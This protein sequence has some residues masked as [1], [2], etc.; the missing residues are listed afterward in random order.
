MIINDIGFDIATDSN[1]FLN[2]TLNVRIEMPQ[3]VLNV[4]KL[5][6][7]F[8]SHRPY[9]HHAYS[10]TKQQTVRRSDKKE[11]NFIY[12]IDSYKSIICRSVSQSQTFWTLNE[13]FN[14][15][16]YHRYIRILS[17]SH[18]HRLLCMHIF[19]FPMNQFKCIWEWVEPSVCLSVCMDVFVWWLIFK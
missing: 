16:K 7:D 15:Y 11:R 9:K 12:L 10:S 5:L 3:S 14:M 2:F 8:P 19:A 17:L 4:W 6:D 1:L 18:S 13:K